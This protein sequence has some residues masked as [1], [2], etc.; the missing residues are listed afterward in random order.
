MI[1]LMTAAIF[2]LA[3]SAEEPAKVDWLSG[4]SLSRAKELAIS[5]RWSDVP[6][7]DRLLRLAYHQ[8]IPIFVDRRVDPSTPLNF[9]IRQKTW[10]QLLWTVAE[11]LEL[12]ICEIENLYYVTPP[13]QALPIRLTFEQNRERLRKDRKQLRA[14]WLRPTTFEIPEYSQPRLLIEQLAEQHGI[15][16]IGLD[17][18]P[19][20]I[21]PAYRLPPLD[22]LE[23]FTLLLSGFGLAPAISADGTVVT[24][25]KTPDFATARIQIPIAEGPKPVAKA[26]AK[27]FK[28]LSIKAYSQGLIVEGP[29]TEITALT[30]QVVRI[31]TPIVGTETKK[32][33]SVTASR[34]NILATMA[35]QLGT[36]FTFAAGDRP[37][38]EQQV[39]IKMT[40]VTEE[41][42]IQ[43]VLEGT[44]LTYQ[45][46]DKELI[47][48]GK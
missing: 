20:D 28:N 43:K 5:V 11:A 31:Q 18:I 3:S 1:T 45:L 17:L 6:L 25:K 34:G 37:T 40:G 9:D 13:G 32:D 22:L 12:E 10:E 36:Q 2:L 26:L 33:F 16:V 21:W 8:G 29:V 41:D 42:I 44:P 35:Q 4:K 39:T 38:L 47:I 27:Q 23:K 15:S 19:L 48:I 7:R 24:V 30:A 46:T 14:P